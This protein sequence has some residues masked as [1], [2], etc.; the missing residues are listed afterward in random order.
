MF[1]V[2]VVGKLPY[3]GCPFC[4]ICK[5][6]I[7]KLSLPDFCFCRCKDYYLRLDRRLFARRDVRKCLLKCRE[8][9]IF[10]FCLLCKSAFS[11]ILKIVDRRFGFITL[12]PILY[13]DVCEGEKKVSLLLYHLRHLKKRRVK[14]C[15]FTVAPNKRFMVLGSV[16]SSVDGGGHPCEGVGPQNGMPP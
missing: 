9:L 12:V 14:C 10:F 15:I 7:S 11:N 3:L 5:S 1:T 16:S 6:L 4:L 2:F 13:V 8:S